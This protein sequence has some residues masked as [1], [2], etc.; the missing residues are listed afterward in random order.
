MIR[1][2]KDGKMRLMTARERFSKFVTEIW[3]TVRYVIESD[4]MRNLP[5]DVMWELSRRI[6][7]TVR[8]DKYEVET[9]EEMKERVDES[10]DLADWIVIGVEGARRLGFTIAKMEIVQPHRQ[11]DQW[12]KDL[13]QRQDRLRSRNQLT[14]V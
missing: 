4:Q 2:L 6:W 9:K 1:D 5:E 13:M 10:P 7:R 12:K 3:W 8:G 11:T 14:R